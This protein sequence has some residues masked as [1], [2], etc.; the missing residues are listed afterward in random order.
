M[1][2]EA[3]GTQGINLPNTAFSWVVYMMLIRA[4]STARTQRLD[5]EKR[6]ICRNTGEQVVD[7]KYY[8]S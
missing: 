8:S 4:N 2:E 1:G 3:D 5:G 7:G 6:D